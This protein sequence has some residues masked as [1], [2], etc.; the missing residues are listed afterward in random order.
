MINLYDFDGTIYDGDS[1]VDFYFF[2]LKRKPIIIIYLL[3]FL[4]YGILYI[5]NI[6]SKTKMK[7]KFFAFLNRFS[8]VDELVEDFWKNNYRKIKRFYIDKNHKDDIIISASP[9]FLLKTACRKLKVKKLIASPVNKNNGMY[10]GNNCDGKEKVVRLEKECGKVK[11]N[12]VYSDSYNDTPIWLL[13][14]KA[15]L[16]KK[17]NITLL[18]K[19]KLKNKKKSN[20]YKRLMSILFIFSTPFMTMLFCGGEVEK[21]LYLMKYLFLCSFLISILLNGLLFNSFDKKINMKLM[22]VSII[23]SLFLVNTIFNYSVS[24]SYFI[25][26]VLNNYFNVSLNI[27]FVKC[28][29]SFLALPSISIFIYYFIIKIFPFMKKEFL[30]LSK[31]EKRFLFILAIIGFLLTLIIY[32]KTNAFYLPNYCLNNNCHFGNS[33]VIYTTDSGMLN[34]NNTY[35]NVS[36]SE[37]DIRQPLFGI[38]ALPFSL[39]AKFISNFLLFVPNA[40]YIVFNTIQILLLGIIILMINRMLDSKKGSF[41]CLLLLFLSSFSFILFSFVSEQ[42]IISLFYLI[43]TIY[44]WYFYDFE[45]N[46]SYVGALGSL[47]TSGI[48]FPLVNNKHVKSLKLWFKSLFK[49]FLSFSVMLLLTGQ[50]IAF[51]KERIMFL[52]KF[53]GVKL[54]F[55]DKFKQFLFFVRS[56]FIAPDGGKILFKNGYICYR[57]NEI[58]FISFVGIIILVLCFIS[59]IVNRKKVF[60]VISFLWI[61]F[62]FVILCVIGWGTQENGLILYSLYFFWA[63]ISLIYLLIDKIKN[64][65]IRVLIYSLLILIMLI[66]NLREFFN[67]FNFAIKYYPN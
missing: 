28:I 45:T 40:F 53:T 31:Y 52:F 67:I 13:G 27:I 33:D 44:F 22:I 56:I 16:V 38:L 21:Y 36:F 66:F 1:T 7:E 43:L 35:M 51:S 14:K 18:D 59:F 48:L 30:S 39:I 61:I 32:S 42:Y 62:S 65:R 19:S 26:N 15:Y 6:V 20:R 29:I 2:C 11:V 3:L 10:E 55:V 9:Y 23:I 34:K 24:G 54:S 63:Y 50:I 58:S 25:K 4:V 12:E 41:I 60:A 46:Y 47:I 5:F 17:N 8:N 57:L 49:V 64:K 37:N